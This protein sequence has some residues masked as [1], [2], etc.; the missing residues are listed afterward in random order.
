M[1]KIKQKIIN[2][3][4][5]IWTQVKDWHNLVILLIVAPTLFCLCILLVG[6]GLFFTDGKIHLITAAGIVTA[7][8]MGPFTP[9][10]PL[11]I[12]ITFGI[13]KFIDSIWKPR[14]LKKADIENDRTA[15]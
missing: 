5:W 1:D 14:K 12:A 10:W 8:W 9:F 7:F 2:F 3:C 13:R 6:I 4:K 11:C 15:Q